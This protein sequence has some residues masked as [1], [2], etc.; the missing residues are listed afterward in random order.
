M[1]QL[2]L[3]LLGLGSLFLTACE[4][5]AQT[6]AVADASEISLNITGMT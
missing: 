2:L 5:G 3:V 1:K 6:Q 4:N